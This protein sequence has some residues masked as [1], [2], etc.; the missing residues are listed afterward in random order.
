VV[1][2]EGPQRI[3]VYRREK[4]GAGHVLPGPCLIESTETTVLVPAGT[5]CEIDPLGTAVIT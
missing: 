3:P 2:P 4:L 1:L 5:T